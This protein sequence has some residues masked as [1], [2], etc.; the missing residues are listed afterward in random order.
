MALNFEPANLGGVNSGSDPEW[1]AILEQI[2]QEQETQQAE[3]EQFH[4]QAQIE[5][6][7]ARQSVEAAKTQHPVELSEEPAWRELTNQVAAAP[8]PL[9]MP[10]EPSV[11]GLLEAAASA[12]LPA[13]AAMA[14]RKKERQ[15]FYAR[16]D[17]TI[18]PVAQSQL[19]Q[20][21]ERGELPWTTLVWNKT[22]AEWSKAADTEL[23]ELSET[24]PPPLPSVAK[25]QSPR[26]TCSAC[27]H[28]LTATDRFCPACGRPLTS[29]PPTR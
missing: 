13:A 4:T 21:F 20:L 7:Q 29:P 24:P 16:E 12:L 11:G 6:E 22:L 2:N 25:A 3:W 14:A 18:G 8:T 15:W 5:T 1:E 28:E 10:A 19:L 9:E 23:V 17:K 26:P 27:G